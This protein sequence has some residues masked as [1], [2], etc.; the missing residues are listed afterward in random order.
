MA[1]TTHQWCLYYFKVGVEHL[2][3]KG[4]DVVAQC[5][6]RHAIHFRMPC[7]DD[8][9]EGHEKLSCTMRMLPGDIVA[10]RARAVRDGKEMPL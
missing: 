3:Q 8:K 9:V 2:C 1:M 5:G 6:G 7:N 10:A 4:L